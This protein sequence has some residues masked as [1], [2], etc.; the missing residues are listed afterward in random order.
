MFDSDN[1]F[2]LHW[3]GLQL[4][5]VSMVSL[6]TTLRFTIPARQVRIPVETILL[7]HRRRAVR[8]RR[9]SLLLVKALRRI[10]TKLHSRLRNQ[11]R[12][13]T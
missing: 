4:L 1:A 2:K 10:S 11:V 5:M 7:L 12:A 6:A 13:A 3:R 8:P 9:Q